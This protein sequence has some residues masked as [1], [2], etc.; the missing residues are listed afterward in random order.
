MERESELRVVQ[1][2]LAQFPFQAYFKSIIHHDG[3]LPSNGA[4]QPS[5]LRLVIRLRLHRLHG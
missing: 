5:T 1:L 4:S 3:A 2:T